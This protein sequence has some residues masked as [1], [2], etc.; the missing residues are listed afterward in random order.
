MI[1]PAWCP[2]SEVYETVIL[3]GMTY[4]CQIWSV[5]VTKSIRL[6]MCENRIPRMLGY[7]KEEV[8]VGWRK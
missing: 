1:I 5:T 4:G 8:M 6:R 3:P 2:E 7:E